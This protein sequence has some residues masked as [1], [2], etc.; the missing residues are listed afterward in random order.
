MTNVQVTMNNNMTEK[1]ACTMAAANEKSNFVIFQLSNILK[2]LLLFMRIYS[3]KTFD[4]MLEA[5]IRLRED[6][7]QKKSAN[8]NPATVFFK[9]NLYETAI[10]YNII[11][12]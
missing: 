10:Q 7:P 5:L 2:Q 3:E 4:R 12:L 1:E 9:N 6:M 11:I 8:S